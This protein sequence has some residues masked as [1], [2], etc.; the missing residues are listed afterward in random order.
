M[1]TVMIDAGHGGRDPGAVYQGRQEKNDAL[2]LALEVGNILQ[3]RGIDVEY[4]RTTDVYNTPLE[5]AQIANKAGSDYF[6]S[7]HRNALEN[8]NTGSG[9][10]S[11]VYDD[12]GVKAEMARNINSRLSA[13]GLKDLGVVE[14]PNLVVLRRTAMPAV[15]VEAGFIDSDKDNEMFDMRF[16][17]I[18]AAIAD[19]IIDTISPPVTKASSD[20]SM[21]EVE[22]QKVLFQEM[23]EDELHLNQMNTLYRVQVGA[24]SN[25]MSAEQLANQL[26][27]QG[28]PAFVLFSNGLY[29]VQVGAYRSLDNAVRM[30]RQLRMMG[31][32]TFITTM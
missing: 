19:G 6:V 31:Y 17:E 28:Y 1:P 22:E 23:E 13:L 10:M 32:P 27:S 24:F 12:S 21:E 8:P 3:D 2:A 16:N 26:Q 15:L 5:K 29:K 30:E 7:I 18:A 4:T 20:V 11:L 9:I 14:R 25:Q